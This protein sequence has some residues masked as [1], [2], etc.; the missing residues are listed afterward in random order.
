MMFDRDCGN[1]EEDMREILRTTLLLGIAW[2]MADAVH[3]DSSGKVVEESWDSAHLE[4]ARVGFLH[5][6][7]RRVEAE[8]GKRLYT[9]A[10]LE[11]TFKR[12]NALLR[13]RREYGTEETNDGKVVGVFMR[14]GQEGGR[15]LVL[16]GSLEDGRMHVR[17]DN[18]R[19]ERRLRWSDD[20]VGLHGLEHRFAERKP[21]A[22]D[23]WTLKR[24][25]PTYNAVVVF[26]AA[27]KEREEVALT[28][29][30]A[31]VKL[32]RVE[33]AAEA[34]EAPGIKVQPPEE[35]W[36]LDERFVPV[37]R[38]FDL[39]GLGTL[40]LTRTTRQTAQAAGSTS[41]S[42]DI[43]L[44]SLLPLNRSLVRPYA[45][46]AVVYRVGLRG[47]R[48]PA[49]AL[50]HDAHQEIRNVRGATFEL[51]VHP[52]RQPEHRAD[53]AAAAKEYR[54]SCHFLDC[55]DGRIQELARRAA[56][57]EKE[58]WAKAKRIE[59]WV[60]QNMRVDQTAE[61]APASVAAR[62]LRGD[63]RQ[64]SLLTSA[65]CRAQGIPSRTAIGLLYVEKNR[66]PTMGFHMWTEVCIDGQWLGLDATLGLGGVSA[67]HVKISDH[68][69]HD[70]PSLTPLLPVSRVLGK[71]TIAVVSDDSTE[72]QR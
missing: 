20:I 45:T 63:C 25:D 60:K 38:Q 56:G 32:L 52:P 18:G 48:D 15:Q 53:A 72:P 70:T 65:M 37:R 19:I 22:G 30:A 1:G 51:H 57:A 7:V 58:A 42:L 35:V 3:A 49:S 67:A 36:W 13:L 16:S 39:E 47:D 14:Q 26:H 34:L 21:K 2:A 8:D 24:Y 64:F 12:N 6:T 50:V 55:A 9:T 54:E 44:K 5:T 29:G 43:G 40:V 31:R 4:G 69:W 33:M 46:R 41:R 61:M 71:M 62:Q 23:R 11:L 68:S 27:F 59:R 17:I 66:R 10:E 28:P